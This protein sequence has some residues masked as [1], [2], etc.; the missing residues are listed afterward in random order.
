[1]SLS[2]FERCT[3]SEFSAVAERWKERQERESRQ[4]WERTRL[5]AAMSLQPYSKKPV[6]PT[7]VMRFPWDGGAKA[8]AGHQGPPSTKERMDEIAERVR[9]FR[10][11]RNPC[12]SEEDR[13][14]GCQPSS[15]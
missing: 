3:P 5:L 14:T 11:G 15:R 8:G 10:N 13:E 1:M 2:D 12:A 9:R 4:E 7:D 6:R